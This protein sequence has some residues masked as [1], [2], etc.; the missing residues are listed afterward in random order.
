MIK[1]SNFSSLWFGPWRNGFDESAEYVQKFAEGDNIVVQVDISGSDQ[2]GELPM[3]FLQNIDDAEDSG[4][5]KLPF[6]NDGFWTYTLSPGLG[7]WKVYLRGTTQN[8][9]FATARFDVLPAECLQNTVK[10]S[11]THRRNDY[12]T[13][14]VR[15]D[16]GESITFDIRFEGGFIFR[17][18]EYAV[19]E[20]T[21]RNQNYV[22]SL[23]SA[24]PY[25]KRTLTLGNAFGVPEWA[26]LKLN[27][28]FSL[29]L[30]EIDGKKYVRSDGEV[31]ER[32][33]LRDNYPLYVWKLAV[34][35]DDFYNTDLEAAS[36][37]P[38]GTLTDNLGDYLTDN[39]GNY[40]TEN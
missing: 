6:F 21:Y 10:I 16:T 34:E 2:A 13:I 5:L 30:V 36:G 9:L 37:V 33:E 12:G 24:F 27:L 23:T 25:H 1:V 17:E 20:E 4:V 19:E 11:Y 38:A 15:P 26:G 40:L 18:T 31:P 14:F 35:P 32:T 3:L 39:L 8:L 29:S 7:R 28:I 22:Q